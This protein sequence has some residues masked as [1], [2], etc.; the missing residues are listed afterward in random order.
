MTNV[1]LEILKL[2]D[3]E[4][5]VEGEGKTIPLGAPFLDNPLRFVHYNPRDL[6]LTLRRLGFYR[7]FLWSDNKENYCKLPENIWHDADHTL[8]LYTEFGPPVLGS[9]TRSSGL[10][11][12][13]FNRADCISEQ[14]G[15]KRCLPIQGQ[16]FDITQFQ[17]AQ[18]T[19]EREMFPYVGF[20]KFRDLF[21]H[22]LEQLAWRLNNHY[23]F[24]MNYISVSEETSYDD[25]RSMFNV[26]KEG[27]VEEKEDL[28]V[29]ELERIREERKNWARLYGF[30][31][32]LILSDRFSG[33]HTSYA[34]AVVDIQP[35]Q[36]LQAHF[37]L[38]GL[39]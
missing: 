38:L 26:M 19:N 23:S 10:A 14:T 27:Y 21:T 13:G 4:I 12:C 22:I 25:T 17:T 9:R 34:K 7:I 8:I 2:K 6:N 33:K 30:G 15:P 31:K 35:D 16:T 32:T 28:V 1:R 29:A 18:F 5:G 20:I 36:K 39:K 37:G 11:I 3:R 24:P